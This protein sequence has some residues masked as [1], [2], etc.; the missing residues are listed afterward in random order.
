[1]ISPLP[2]SDRSPAAPPA[3][4]VVEGKPSRPAGQILVFAG[5]TVVLLAAAWWFRPSHPAAAPAVV[6]PTTRVARG[7]LETT[8]RLAGSITAGHFVNVAAPVLRAPD[9]GRGL[10][11]TF[12]ATSGRRVK[13]GDVVAEIDTAD[14]LDHIDDVQADVVQSA[15]DI[16]R[17]RAVYV[18]QLESLRQRLR[19]CKATL[20]KAKQDLSKFMAASSL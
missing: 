18:A 10:T 19:V 17:R 20:E 2:K 7:S 12:L 16:K 4:A 14:V 5:V 1:M 8:R 6:V 15:L 9:Q 11:L 13:E 3:L